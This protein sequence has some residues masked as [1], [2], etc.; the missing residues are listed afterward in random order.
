SSD[1]DC[2]AGWIPCTHPQ[3]RQPPRASAEGFRHSGLTSASI[4]EPRLP[5]APPGAPP[6]LV[7]RCNR[8]ARRGAYHPVVHSL[9]YLAAGTGFRRPA[10][11]GR[12][13]TEWTPGAV[14]RLVLGVGAVSQ[15][16]IL[17]LCQ[18]SCTRLCTAS[19]GSAADRRP[20]RR[21]GAH[22]TNGHLD[23]GALVA[24]WAA[25]LAGLW[26]FRRALGGPGILPQLVSYRLPLAVS[27]RR[28]YRYL[29]G[30]L[31]ATGWRLAGWFSQ[32][33]QCLSA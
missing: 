17:G 15:R 22:S 13:G 27:G 3:R 33:V 25:R 16:Y 10:V 2:R 26:R 29:A 7:G 14:A 4:H 1:L 9:R 6:R 23:L 18:H 24:P 30:R 28:P 12:A 5:A 32:C 20:G 21:P 8:P 11:P 19:T 31:G